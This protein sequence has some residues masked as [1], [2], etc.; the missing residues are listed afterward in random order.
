MFTGFSI[1]SLLYIKI[2][3]QFTFRNILNIPKISN[4]CFPGLIYR[5]TC[6]LSLVEFKSF[7]EN[8][9]IEQWS[10]G[11]LLNLYFV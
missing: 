2:S 9:K 4:I 3:P 7:T 5:K 10:G 11:F 8:Q 1:C 6:K